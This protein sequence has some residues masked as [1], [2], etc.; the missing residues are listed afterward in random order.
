MEGAEQICPEGVNGQPGA[1][2]CPEPAEVMGIN[3]H[4]FPENKDKSGN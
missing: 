4:I 1:G 2:R 3:F